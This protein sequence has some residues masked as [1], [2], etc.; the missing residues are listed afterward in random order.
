MRSA[1]PVLVAALV[2]GAGVQ[3]VGGVE[4]MLGRGTSDLS[5][6]VSPDFEGVT[7]DTLSF[8]VGYGYFLWDRLELRL[9]ADYATIEDVAPG[10]QDYRAREVDL[11]ACRP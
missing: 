1:G 4:P 6:E 11:G 3:T 9:A 2:V 5:L 8:T 10:E 7:G